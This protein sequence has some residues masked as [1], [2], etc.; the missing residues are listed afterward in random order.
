MNIQL[1]SVTEQSK[2]S[3]NHLNNK[4]HKLERE[5]E[6]LNHLIQSEK[7]KPIRA[8]NSS[9]LTSEDHLKVVNKIKKDKKQRDQK[10]E[11]YVKDLGEKREEQ[12]TK[13]RLLS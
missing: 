13:E 3:L 6:L 8:L 11:M 10:R 5:L 4:K 12:Q 2:S 1:G 7:F 9:G